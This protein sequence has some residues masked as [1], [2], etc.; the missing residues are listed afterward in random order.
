MATPE[1][2]IPYDISYLYK[3]IKIT[4]L[5][6]V[7]DCEPKTF[8]KQYF[9]FFISFPFYFL[10]NSFSICFPFPFLS[11]FFYFPFIFPFSIPLAFLLLSFYFPFPYLL[12]SLSFPYLSFSF[13]SLLT[14]PSPFI[15]HY[16]PSIMY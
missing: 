12:L 15:L 3:N 5:K 7:L 16:F 10:S 13:P 6:K 1:L 4:R 14:F 2:L 8:I 9:Q 11:F